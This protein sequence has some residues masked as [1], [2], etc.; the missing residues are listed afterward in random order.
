MNNFILQKLLEHVYEQEI[1]DYQRKEETRNV[2]DQNQRGR[3]PNFSQT[4][5]SVDEEQEQTLLA[6]VHSGGDENHGVAG[7][8]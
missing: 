8:N 6:K 2:E 1:L 3:T 7:I 5:K 4:E